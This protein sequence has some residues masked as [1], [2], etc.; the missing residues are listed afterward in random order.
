MR[1]HKSK[2]L[3]RIGDPTLLGLL[4]LFAFFS[5]FAVNF[6]YGADSIDSNSIYYE[7]AQLEDYYEQHQ[8]KQI[9]FFASA[10]VAHIIP[11]RDTITFTGGYDYIDVRVAPD[12]YDISSDRESH[13]NNYQRYLDYRG[14]S[15]APYIALSQK[16]FGI[17]FAAE[18][19]KRNIHYLD[20]SFAY[21][22]DRVTY[23]LEL[24][25]QISYS[26]IGLYAYYIPTLSI[27]PRYVTST[28]ILGVKNIAAIQEESDPT[29]LTSVTSSS[30]KYRYQVQKYE[31]GANIGIL[32]VKRFTVF[33]WANY[34]STVTGEIASSSETLSD[35][36]R[37]EARALSQEFYWK[38]EPQLTYGLDFSVNL[39]RFEIHLGGVL[40]MIGNISSGD[41]RINSRCVSLSLSYDIKGR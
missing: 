17:G 2:I 37:K 20:E 8:K 28:L 22:S 24:N 6:A 31:G 15:A 13:P 21:N 18:V 19:G 12:G 27:L 9:P 3:A 5:F 7:G 11:K 26:G 40:G 14:W 39:D 34:T 1:E 41:N 36:S 35:T 30:T 23:R 25:S 32:L 29:T 4:V 16:N 10:P 33:P 38:S